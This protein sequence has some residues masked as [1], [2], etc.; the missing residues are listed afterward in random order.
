MK[1]LSVAIR[2]ALPCKPRSRLLFRT[3]VTN[4]YDP[5]VMGDW[6]FDQL[7]CDPSDST[8]ELR[9]GQR[10]RVRWPNPDKAASAGGVLADGFDMRGAICRVRGTSTPITTVLAQLDEGTGQFPPPVETVI[11]YFVAV[12]P[13]VWENLRYERARTILGR[14]QAKRESERERERE[15]DRGNRKLSLFR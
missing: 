3:D 8:A 5:V 9:L 11:S 1:R 13:S 12:L 10:G 2:L 15:A 7:N 4:R 6:S 14:L